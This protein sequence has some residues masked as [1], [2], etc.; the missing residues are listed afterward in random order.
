MNRGRVILWMTVICG[1]GGCSTFDQ[2]ADS[3]WTPERAQRWYDEQP[4]LVGCNFIPSTA[5]N[6]LEMWQ[7]E[8]FDPGT[9][10]R[11]LGWASS[12]GFNTVRVYLHDLAW[13]A[14]RRGF[15]KRIDHFLEIAGRYG[16]RPMFVLFDDCWTDHPKP[17]R[18]PAPIPGVH[19]SGWVRS[20][21]SRAVTDPNSWP[22]LERYVKDIIATFGRDRRILMWDLYN[23]P[24]NSR[25]GNQSLPLL[26][27]AFAWARD[28]RPRHPL[29]AGVWTANLK[30]LAAYQLGVSDVITFH[31]YNDAD[32]LRSQI[33]RLRSHERPLICTEYMARTNNS[34]FETHLPIFKDERIGCYSWGL[35]GGKTQTIYPWGSPQG[36]P[37]PTVWFHDMLERDGTPF[38]PKEV[39]FVRAL[40]HE[41]RQAEQDAGP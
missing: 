40:L 3:R 22:R 31:N 8:T 33:D 18:Q 34:R 5:V 9:I 35:V 25:M 32:A 10:D 19:N 39:R 6:Q 41:A 14:D 21:G 16:I 36:A 20:P 7:A 15:K 13:E 24:G 12:I 30:E 11:E 26:K 28:V 38:D 1:V 27:A 37:E 29:T 2:R 17:G 23:E 4:W